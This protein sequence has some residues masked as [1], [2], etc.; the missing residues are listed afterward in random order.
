VFTG[1]LLPIAPIRDRAVA[2]F[3]N[4]TVW[5]F[6]EGESVT[7]PTTAMVGIAATEDA[8]RAD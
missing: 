5:D 3:G 1:G 7:Q 4:L 6:V 8:M 2:H